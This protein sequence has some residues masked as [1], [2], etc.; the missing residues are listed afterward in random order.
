M[1]RCERIIAANLEAPEELADEVCESVCVS[2]C[3]RVMH[4]RERIIAANQ[5]CLGW[6]QGLAMSCNVLQGLSVLQ[7]QPNN[8][9]LAMSCNVLQG[10]GARGTRKLRCVCNVCVNTQHNTHSKLAMCSV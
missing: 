5:Q 6:Q 7:C 3:V 10:L 2:E 9:C 1:H 8:Q 4:R